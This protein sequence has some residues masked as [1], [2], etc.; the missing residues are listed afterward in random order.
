MMKDV[1]AFAFLDFHAALQWRVLQCCCH[2][3]GVQVQAGGEPID[4]GLCGVLGGLQVQWTLMTALMKHL[5]R[6]S[7][8]DLD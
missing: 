2:F 8:Q 5:K 7:V 6:I 4:D 1:S 3:H